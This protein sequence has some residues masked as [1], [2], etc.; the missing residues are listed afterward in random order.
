[1]TSSKR[2]DIMITLQ[3]TPTR[4]QTERVKM[5][6]EL[7]VV[8]ADALKNSAVN[9]PRRTRDGRPNEEWVRGRCPECGDDLVSNFYYIGGKGYLLVWECWDSLREDPQCSYRRVL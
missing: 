9:T 2:K 6:E 3:S 5:M 4:K 8:E 1:M 7:L